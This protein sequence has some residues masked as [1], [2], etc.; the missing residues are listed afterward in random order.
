MRFSKT[1]P[2]TSQFCILRIKL[3]S[4]VH[5]V[6][7]TVAFKFWVKLCNA[8][9]YHRCMFTSEIIFTQAGLIQNIQ[10]RFYEWPQIIIR[11]SHGHKV[12]NKNAVHLPNSMCT[13]LSL[14][15]YLK[16]G[17]TKIYIF[18]YKFKI[19]SKNSHLTSCLQ[20]SMVNMSNECSQ[21][22]NV[23]IIFYFSKMFSI[24]L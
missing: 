6:P 1:Y 16:G 19:I 12:L 3:S 17:R 22:G 13:I 24:F 8:H 2:C 23:N 18:E 7:I 11:C 5:L 15:Q 4:K 21:V 10:F 9:R 20:L 14:S